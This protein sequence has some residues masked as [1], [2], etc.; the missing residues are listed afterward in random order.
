MN[1]D[2][3]AALVLKDAHIG[4]ECWIVGKGPSI[5]FLNESYFGSGPVLTINEA[6]LK[7]QELNIPNP[8][9]S[10]QKDGFQWLMVRPK[11]EVTLILQSILSEY[12]FKDHPKRLVINPMTEWGF[13]VTEMSIRMCVALAKLMGCERISFVCCDSL[14]TEDYRMYDV[15]H[16]TITKRDLTGF[17]SHVKPLVLEDVKDMP[18]RFI[19]PSEALC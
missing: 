4:Q 7:V 6:V 2:I 15:A 5:A 3:N 10:M 11:D 13:A 16:E 19:L 9:Y 1:D 8:I 18:H 14:T 12:W 17:Y